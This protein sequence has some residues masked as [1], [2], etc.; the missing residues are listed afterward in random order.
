MSART[1]DLPAPEEPTNAKVAF[2]EF[3]AGVSVN[4]LHDYNETPTDPSGGAAPATYPF[5][6]HAIARFAY[7]LGLGVQRNFLFQHTHPAA[8]RLEYQYLNTGE[9]KLGKMKN[10]DSTG[11]SLSFKSL[12]YNVINL[13]VSFYY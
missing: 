3:G 5:K 10:Q 13:F 12:K 6:N 8:I 9:A 1:V 11:K 2:A 7:S 4:T